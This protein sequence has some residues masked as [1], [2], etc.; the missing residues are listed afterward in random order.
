M[1]QLRSQTGTIGDILCIRTMVAI[2]VTL[3]LRLPVRG[4][5]DER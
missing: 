4:I 2:L 5:E 3:S 1:N